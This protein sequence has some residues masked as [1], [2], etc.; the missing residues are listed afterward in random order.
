MALGVRA[1]N[2]KLK[3]VVGAKRDGEVTHRL[4]PSRCTRR[5]AAYPRLPITVKQR[6][7]PLLLTPAPLGEVTDDAGDPK[8][9]PLGVRTAQMLHDCHFFT[10]SESR[11]PSSTKSSVRYSRSAHSIA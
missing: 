8:P 7:E 5:R 6:L 1:G 2:E 3:L 9:L 4:S 10:S 11:L